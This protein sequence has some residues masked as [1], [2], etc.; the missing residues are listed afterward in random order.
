MALQIEGRIV[1]NEKIG[2]LYFLL[3][4]DCPPLAAEI[5]PG[6]FIMLK[7]SP[8]H[9]THPLLKRPFSVY[10]TFPPVHRERSCRGHVLFLYKEVGKGTQKMTKFRRGETV[11]MIGPLGNG[12]T[13]PSL[14]SPSPILLIGGGVGIVTLY[15]LAELLKSSKLFVLIGGRTAE[16]ILCEKDFT[17]LPSSKVFIATEDGSAGYRGT[18]IELFL[19][20]MERF[21]RNNVRY[22]YSCGPAGMLQD[23]AK[24]KES[25]GFVCQVSLE[26]RMACGF[27]ACWG[28]VVKTT[29]RTVPYHRVCTDGPVF[30]L[31]DILWK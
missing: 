20:Q 10:K 18:V 31:K 5:K 14:P 12:F 4:I 30:N 22:I 1:K 25:E 13:L 21:E 6:Q 29:E 19:S 3:E 8:A 28:C 16:D 15:P 27:G 2:S 7:A 9:D 26:S 24:R 23:L 17:Q 11:D